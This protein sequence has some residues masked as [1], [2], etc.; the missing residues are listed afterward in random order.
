MLSLRVTFLVYLALSILHVCVSAQNLVKVI[1]YQYQGQALDGSLKDGVVGYHINYGSSHG[2]W[3]VV[4]VGGNQITLQN[5]AT[6]LYLRPSSESEG[7][8][9]T[10][11][12]E[13]YNWQQRPVPG[14]WYQIATNDG[15]YVLLLTDSSDYSPVVL[16]GAS[17]YGKDSQW[18]YEPTPNVPQTQPDCRQRRIFYKKMHHEIMNQNFA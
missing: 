12:N 8:R 17:Y 6:G 10:V 13:P 18:G 16:K 15:R 14:G 9:V 4:A 5:G 2:S 1:N 11:G 7:Q 3:G